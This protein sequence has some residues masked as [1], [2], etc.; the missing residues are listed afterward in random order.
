MFK[1]DKYKQNFTDNKEFKTHTTSCHLRNYKCNMC[2]ENFSNSFQMEGHL[3][4]VHKKKK[5][6]KWDKCDLSFLLEWRLKKHIET[7]NEEKIRTCYYYN[8]NIQ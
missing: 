1:C 8:N 3:I 6:Y 2:D 5:S 4:N 7:H